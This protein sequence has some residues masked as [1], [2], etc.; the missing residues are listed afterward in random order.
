MTGSVDLQVSE[1]AQIKLIP[2]TYLAKETFKPFHLVLVSKEDR[3]V[4]GYKNPCRE[5]QLIWG[6]L[7]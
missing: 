1:S 2:S 5:E 7:R 4:A 3:R 6:F